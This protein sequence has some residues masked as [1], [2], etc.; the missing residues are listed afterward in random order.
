MLLKNQNFHYSQVIHEILA[1]V[2]MGKFT[3]PL[4]FPIH[5]RRS[6]I[7]ARL[8]QYSGRVYVCT[9][10]VSYFLMLWLGGGG[11]VVVGAS[12][13]TLEGRPFHCSLGSLISEIVNHPWEHAFQ[14]QT[15]NPQPTSFTPSLNRLTNSRP[16]FTCPNH[17]RLRYQTIRTAPMPQSLLEFVKPANLKPACLASPLPSWENPMKFL[18]QVPPP[19]VSWP[20][21]GLPHSSHPPCGA[22]SMVWHDCPLGV[23]EC[24][25]ASFQWQLSSDLQMLPSLNNNK[26][27]IF[28]TI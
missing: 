11:A 3:R 18:M 23:C 6:Q 28:K 10:Y 16:L 26:A 17:S 19:S 4:P 25:K 9:S 15:N 13:L 21:L 1:S 27:Y 22:A 14:M 5:V 12:L 8:F 2:F 24:N 7:H 20:M